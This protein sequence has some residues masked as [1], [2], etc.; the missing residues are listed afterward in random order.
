VYPD[1]KLELKNPIRTQKK[2]KGFWNNVENQRLFFTELASS[3]NIKNP[4]DWYKVKV[5]HS[6]SFLIIKLSDVLRHPGGN[7]ILEQYKGSFAKALIYLHL[8]VLYSEG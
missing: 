5:R 2:P 7:S 3:M 4:E 1:L 8:F 6:I